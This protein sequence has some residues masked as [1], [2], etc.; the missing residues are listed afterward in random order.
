MCPCLAYGNKEQFL[1]FCKDI[2]S[3]TSVNLEEIK[4]DYIKNKYVCYHDQDFLVLNKNRLENYNICPARKYVMP[5]IHNDLKMKDCGIIHFSHTSVEKTQE[6]FPKLKEI[7]SDELRIKL[8]KELKNNTINYLTHLR[9]FRSAGGGST[10]QESTEFNDIGLKLA[11]V[12]AKE[13]FPS[14]QQFLKIINFDSFVIEKLDITAPVNQVGESFKRNKSDK[15]GPNHRY[16]LIYQPIFNELG[17]DKKLN[18]LEIGLGTNNVEF[19]SHMGRE[20]R[21]GSSLYAYKELFSNAKIYGADV[22]KEILFEEDRIK[23]SFVDQLDFST[24]R[25]MHNN[26][27]N[28]EYDI[29]IEDGLHSITASLNTLIFGLQTVKNGGYLVLEDLYNPNSIWNF[30]AQVLLNSKTIQSARLVNSGGLML[31]IKK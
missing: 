14:F 16:D 2:I 23:T 25:T 24:F 12:N 5:Y 13:F 8:I 27:N 6:S 20:A 28:P 19:V 3:F 1:S 4:L 15:A 7:K 18:I 31:V 29:L 9:S 30:L 11:L 26:F 10:N 22:D 21:P 17:F